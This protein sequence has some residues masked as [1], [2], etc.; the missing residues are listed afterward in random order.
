MKFTLYTAIS[1]AKYAAESGICHVISAFCTNKVVQTIAITQ[2]I[3]VFGY[4]NC[5]ENGPTLLPLTSK[6]P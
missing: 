2:A 6:K 3:P 1:A 5:R 4:T